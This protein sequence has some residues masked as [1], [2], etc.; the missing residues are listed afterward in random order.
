[1]MEPFESLRFLECPNVK[2]NGG[3]AFLAS[4][5]I[6]G[7]V[8]ALVAFFQGAG[9]G[10]RTDPM[11]FVT[12]SL[13]IGSLAPVRGAKPVTSA[14]SFRGRQDVQVVRSGT[15]AHGATDESMIRETEMDTRTLDNPNPEMET[16]RASADKPETFTGT[17]GTETPVSGNGT[18]NSIIAE[19]GGAASGSGFSAGEGGNAGGVMSK[20]SPLYRR[21]PPSSYPAFA[22]IR[23]FQ[24][25]VELNVLVDR[26]GKVR[27]LNVRKSSGFGVLD[28]AAL[29]S[30]RSWMFKPGWN[31]HGPTDMWVVVP[32]VFR[33]AET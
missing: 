3:A 11:E 7:L 2:K 24:G 4:L 31:E 13:E 16:G 29:A 25:T 19:A 28:H 33:L 26:T 14:V 10:H 15:P 1:M 18:S 8:I 12:V 17:L 6:H 23:G 21:N 9:K 5:A 20:A 30:V 22:R 27:D 32:L